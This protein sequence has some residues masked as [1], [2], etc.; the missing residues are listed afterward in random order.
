MISLSLSLPTHEIQINLVMEFVGSD[1]LHSYLK[2]KPDRRLEESEA[3]RIFQQ[4]ISAVSYMH[5]RN[6]VHRDIKLENILMD[7]KLNTKIIDF[8]FS[9][10]IPPDKKLSIF[11]GT[12]QYMSPEIVAKKEYF[13]SPAD[14]WATGILLFVMLVGSFPF[15]AAD[16]KKLY[17][18]ILKSEFLVP[19]HVSSAAENLLRRLLHQSPTDRI[20]AEEVSLGFSHH[21]CF[22]FS[23]PC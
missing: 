9:I 6:F 13:G 20:T 12:P 4:V 23:A 18:K 19:A 3:K 16:E 22:P 7:D 17:Q 14:V 21:I 11:C 1:S 8:G 2:S 15:R 10:Y 5:E